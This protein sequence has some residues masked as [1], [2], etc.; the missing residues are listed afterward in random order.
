[1]RGRLR[2]TWAVGCVGIAALAMFLHGAMPWAEATPTSPAQKAWQAIDPKVRQ[3][4]DAIGQAADR[5]DFVQRF[6]DTGTLPT[7]PEPSGYIQR[8]TGKEDKIV[9]P[10]P[11]PMP[12]PPPEAPPASFALG[13]VPQS[14]AAPPPPKAMA[15]APAV[16]PPAVAAPPPPPAPT[17]QPASYRQ[18]RMAD[19]RPLGTLLVETIEA[20]DRV[21][22]AKADVEAAQGRARVALGDWFPTLTPTASFGW[23]KQKK[24]QEAQTS[25]GFHEMGMKLSQLLW[26]FGK[27]NAAVEKARLALERSRTSLDAVRRNLILEAATAYANVIRTRRVLEYARR[28]EENIRR[29]T[30][31]EE[32]RVEVGSGLSTDVLQAKRELAAADARRIEA[33]GARIIAENRF[34]SIF[35]FLPTAD[36][37]LVEVQREVLP[38]PKALEQAQGEALERN[39]DLILARIDEDSAREE[40]DATQ[41]GKFLPKVE[42]V[43][44]RKWKQNVSGTLGPK[45]ETLAKVEM[46]VPL[47]MGLTGL[48]AIEAASADLLSRM[49]TRADTRRKVE[50]ETRNAWQQLETAQSKARALRNQENIAAAFLDLAR[51]ERALNQRSLID[52]LTGETALIN[53]QS[54]AAS[55]ETDVLIASFGLLKTTGKLDYSIFGVTVALA[56]LAPEASPEEISGQPRP[57]RRRHVGSASDTAP[58]LPAPPA[59]LARPAELDTLPFP[60]PAKEP[61]GPAPEPKPSVA[62]EPAPEDAPALQ[63]HADLF[64]G[65]LKDHLE[66][67]RDNRP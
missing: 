53:A 33:E 67:P 11:P 54:D 51:K 41:A 55:V 42:G 49:R 26:D 15:F 63:S 61:P 9:L 23:E 43:V 45:N 50:E 5:P 47:N 57:G 20:H 52:L 18:P 13:W 65:W 62:K 29:Q 30:G 7:D 58:S 4:L 24:H 10:L 66:A 37:A 21:Q 31:L 35:G 28:S 44:E 6:V 12:E 64:F 14:P 8:C 1:M 32:A 2:G 59:A 34:L 17:V 22:A 16:P 60:L 38:L 56:A 27:T 25:T 48:D 40:L 36:T 39:S 3:C 19:A 46:S